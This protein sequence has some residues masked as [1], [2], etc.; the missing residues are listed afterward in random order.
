MELTAPRGTQD[1]LP[2]TSEWWQYAES[3]A[4]D[5]A[6]RFNFSEIRTPVFEHT[7]VF[8]RGVGDTTDI[9]EKEMYTFNDKGG[10]SI[11][12]RPEG[13]AGVARAYIQHNLG[14]ASPVQKLYYIAPVFRYERPQA[15]RLRQHHQF[16]AEAIGTM[17]P[18][19][20]A[21]IISLAITL[22]RQFG[23]NDFEVRLNSIGCPSCRPR[24][25]QALVDTLKSR[26]EHLCQTCLSRLERNP[27]RLLDCK[28]PDCQAQMVDLPLVTDF[29]CDD[30]NQHFTLVQ[31]YL[32]L[33]GAAYTIEPRLVRG[34]DYY[35]KTVFEVVYRGLGAQDALCGGGRYDGLVETLGGPPT[36]GVGV[37]IGLERLMI[38]LEKQG[39]LTVPARPLEAFVVTLGEQARHYAVGLAQRLRD[40]RVSVD[41]DYQGRSMK[42][43]MKAAGK[44]EALVAVILGDDEMVSGQAAVRIMRTGEQ[45]QVPLDDIETALVAV[46]MGDAGRRREN[47]ER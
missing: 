40:M 13:T 18:A 27:L 41:M 43:Q 44:S 35:T 8:A 16:G 29:L 21:E 9:V 6:R 46:L 11:T 45:Q 15:G 24:F 7:E 5:V 47:N 33:Q 32:R 42:A 36:P 37:G 34:L 14:S 12:L 17:D 39:R 19:A 3:T 22:Y 31:E 28:N 23:L 20:D 2:G 4:R 10:R 30:C 38:T 26:S 25:R 1:I